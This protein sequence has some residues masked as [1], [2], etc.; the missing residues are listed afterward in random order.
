MVRPQ[1]LASPWRK[2]KSAAEAS[3][4]GDAIPEQNR[5]INSHH[6]TSANPIQKPRRG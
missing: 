3:S 1:S 6:Q 4:G 2:A 5:A